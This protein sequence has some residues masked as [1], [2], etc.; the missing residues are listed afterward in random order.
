MNKHYPITLGQLLI[1]PPRDYRLVGQEGAE[2]DFRDFRWAKLERVSR[3]VNSS[4][5]MPRDE[6][7]LESRANVE[8]QGQVATPAPRLDRTE[9]PGPTNPAL[10]MQFQNSAGID[11]FN[12]GPSLG[13]EQFQ[14]WL[15]QA[16]DCQSHGEQEACAIGQKHIQVGGIVLG[17]PLKDQCQGENA[18]SRYA[19]D[20]R[21]CSV[22]PLGFDH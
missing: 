16:G 4:T 8:I 6:V 15:E 12:P 10:L 13:T 19:P 5:T 22:L 2:Y 9:V 3:D 18:K 11:A 17:S 14:P 21:V 1:L 20:Q 7:L